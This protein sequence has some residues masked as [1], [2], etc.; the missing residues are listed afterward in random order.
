VLFVHGFN[1]FKDWGHFPLITE[2]L[3]EAGFV[4]VRMNLSRNGTTLLRP[5]QIVDLQAYG[6]DLFSVD[7]DD[8]GAAI[9]FL[10]QAERPFAAALDASKVALIGHSRGGALVLLKAGEDARIKAVATWAAI[11]SSRHFWTPANIAEVEKNGVVYVHNGRTKQQLPLYKAYYQD[12]LDNAE[13]LDVEAAVRR[14]RIPVLFAHGTADTSVPVDFAH[15]LH[16]W[17]PD[18][19][20]L[21]IPEA[22][23]TFGG[24]HPYD[25]T[26]LPPLAEQLCAA[27][28]DF[29]RQVLV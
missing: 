21:L 1:A 26:S 27:T 10:T 22:A 24:Y 28:A 9:D 18:S 23:H 19:R 17:K 25:Q 2:Y 3:A 6:N 13:R 5:Q 29:F 12:V 7:L 4:A 14:L 11:K 8:I 16:R 20:L 15:E